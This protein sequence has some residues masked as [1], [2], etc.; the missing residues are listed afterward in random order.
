V[1]SEVIGDPS[2]LGR[3]EDAIWERKVGIKYGPCAVIVISAPG[4]SD[5]RR[6]RQMRK[7]RDLEQGSV[8]DHSQ[9]PFF[10]L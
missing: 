2:R 9:S 4:R 7:P 5:M 8:S 3:I 1:I 6:R 10:L